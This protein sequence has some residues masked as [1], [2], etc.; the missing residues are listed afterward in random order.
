MTRKVMVIA[1]ALWS[2][3]HGQLQNVV[4]RHETLDQCVRASLQLALKE[5]KQTRCMND[6]T[7]GGK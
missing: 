5:G 4:S 6:Y 3:Q 1:F 7:L 2:L